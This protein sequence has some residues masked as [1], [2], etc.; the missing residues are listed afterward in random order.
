MTDTPKEWESK[1]KV[2][3]DK[4]YHWCPG[5]QDKHGPCWVMHHPSDCKA[6]KRGSKKEIPKEEPKPVKSE[7]GEE[8]VGWTTSMLALVHSAESDS[9]SK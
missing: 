8:K 3:E 5:G 6:C 2:V 7:Q 9:D 4:I 1:T